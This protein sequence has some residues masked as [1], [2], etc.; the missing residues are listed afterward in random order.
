MQFLVSDLKKL[1]DSIHFFD[2]AC[3]IKEAMS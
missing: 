3:L 1:L 2:Y